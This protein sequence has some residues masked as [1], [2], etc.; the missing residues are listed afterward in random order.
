MP[1]SGKPAGVKQSFKIG[2]KVREYYTR[3]EMIP[4]IPHTP[5]LFP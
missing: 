1:A 4:E 2:I 3:P 5:E